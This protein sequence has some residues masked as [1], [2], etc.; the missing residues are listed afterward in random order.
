MGGSPPPRR[1]ATPPDSLPCG[2]LCRITPAKRVYGTPAA[3]CKSAKTVLT[4]T[5]RRNPNG[6]NPLWNMGIP[7]AHLPGPGPQ[8]LR[9]GPERRDLAGRG[10][11]DLPE[12][13]PPP[14]TLHRTVRNLAAAAYLSL[15]REPLMK[16]T[17]QPNVRRR[18][19]KHG[20]RAR[21]RTRAGRAIIKRRRTKG[22]DRLSA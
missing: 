6:R 15:P 18:K 16:R 14:L 3:A 1:P 11:R 9:F 17:Y 13:C 4:R 22:R 2:K 21:M 20:F 12:G 5:A 10:S 19:R 7:R 8:G